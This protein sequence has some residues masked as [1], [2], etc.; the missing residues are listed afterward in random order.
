MQTRRLLAPLAAAVLAGSVIAGGG[1]AVA[2]EATGT[3]AGSLDLGSLSSG[4]ADLNIPGV[5]NLSVSVDYKCVTTGEGEDAN[6]T[7]HILTT[8][9]NTGSGVANNIATFTTVPGG[10]AAAQHAVSLE[11]GESIVYTLDAKTDKLA[12]A[13]V[14]AVTYASSLDTNP[15]DNFAISTAPDGC[16]VP[17]VEN[18]DD[19]AA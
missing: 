19:A 12:G 9:K 6:T 14:F 15:F 13:P 7:A 3:G 17:A 8:V 2:D 11:A 4:S 10:E 1:V 5:P 16:E 18:T